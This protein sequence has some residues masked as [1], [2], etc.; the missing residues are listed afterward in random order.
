VSPARV[1]V[2]RAR[3]ADAAAIHALVADYA[4]QGLLLPRTEDEIR[5]HADHFL[6]A[7][8]RKKLLGCVALKPYG[9][10]LAEIRSLAVAPE[11]RGNG[12]GARLL[13]FALAKARRSG[14]ARVFAVTHAAEFFAQQGFTITRR[15]LIP[16]KIARDCHGCPKERTCK[17]IA[18]VATV[19]SQRHP[20]TVLEEC[21]TI[22]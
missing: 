6:V 8:Q 1:R 21:A 2:R 12:L 10:A 20:L 17:L 22:T 13:R 14:F 7:T 5:A 4:E 3:P 19:N 15:H 18:L 9:A 16:E 11:A